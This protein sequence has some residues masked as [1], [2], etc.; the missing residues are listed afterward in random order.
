MATR[1]MITRLGLIR[2]NLVGIV[3]NAMMVMMMI[4]IQIDIAV[5]MTFPPLQLVATKKFH[6]TNCHGCA[7]AS[8]HDVFLRV[9]LFALVAGFNCAHELV[10]GQDCGGRR[11][12]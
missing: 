1:V 5:G 4:F 8:V 7:D 6:R 2:N 3:T 12:S 9:V 10:D 11:A